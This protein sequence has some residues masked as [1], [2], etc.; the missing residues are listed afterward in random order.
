MTADDSPIQ[1]EATALDAVGGQVGLALDSIWS[2]LDGDLDALPTA[3]DGPFTVNVTIEFADPFALPAADDGGLVGQPISVLIPWD[4]EPGYPDPWALPTQGAD[5][6]VYD[7]YDPMTCCADWTMDGWTDTSAF[8]P[9]DGG[10]PGFESTWMTEPGLYYDDSA[11]ST[12]PGYWDTAGY[13]DAASDFYPEPSP[14][15]TDPSVTT[16]TPFTTGYE[17]PPFS[18]GYESTGF[19]VTDTSSGY[20][21]N[22]YYT[23]YDSWE[24]S[25][26]WET[27]TVEDTSVWD[28]EGASAESQF[29]TSEYQDAS[30]LEWDYWNASTDAWLEGDTVLAYE[31]N[32]NSLEAGAYAD[33]AW[34]YSSE[35]WSDP[36]YF[37]T[38]SS[39]DTSSSWDTGSSWDTSTD[40]GS[41]W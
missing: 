15:F 5:W 31:L 16:T 7:P 23:T 13:Y 6:T 26:S 14:S 8:G 25:S 36:A 4:T 34:N 21:P 33:D 24:S 11:F 40:T 22:A 10:T 20:D 1:A 38:S 2:D 35:A 27:P 32:Q 3:T 28:I 17:S 12:I 39:L 41:E 19:D 37:D 30:S 9:F 29:W 18:T